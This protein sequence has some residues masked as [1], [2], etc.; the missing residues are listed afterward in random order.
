MTVRW[1]ECMQCWDG[2]APIQPA[3]SVWMAKNMGRDLAVIGDGGLQQRLSSAI[4][5]IL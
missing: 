1:E 4:C 3:R 2:G 5:L